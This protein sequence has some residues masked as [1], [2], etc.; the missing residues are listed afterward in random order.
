MTQNGVVRSVEAIAAS[1]MGMKNTNSNKLGQLVIQDTVLKER[2]D[3]LVREIDKLIEDYQDSEALLAFIGEMSAGK[4]TIINVLIRYPLLPSASVP[5]S[6]AP[7][8]IR[9]GSVP[10]LEV[11]TIDESGSE[12]QRF[13]FDDPAEIDKNTRRRLLEYA[14]W[15]RENSIIDTESLEYYY[16]LTKTS[17][18]IL[19]DVNDPIRLI[20]L[21]LI[22]LSA[23]TGRGRPELEAVEQYHNAILQQ[24]ELLLSIFG[25]EEDLPYAVRIRLPSDILRNGLVLV[26]L[27]GLGSGNRLHEQITRGYM[28]RADSYILPF[29]PEIRTENCSEALTEIVKYER[30]LSA[31]KDARFIV[32]LN[33]CDT[34]HDAARI[35]TIVQQIHAV[36]TQISIPM[37]YTISAYYGEY[38][39]IEAG[40]PA[41]STRWSREFIP[42][43][44]SMQ[45]LMGNDGAA[46]TDEQLAAILEKKYSS[47]FEYHDPV[48]DADVSI[49]T[50]DF[51]ENVIG[52]FA[53]RIRFLNALEQVNRLMYSHTVF[54]KDLQVRMELVHMLSACGESMMKNLLAII[55]DALEGCTG[56]LVT[57]LQELNSSIRKKHSE[58]AKGIQAA[59]NEYE[60][61]FSA[62]D[63]AMKQHLNQETQKIK[64]NALG[65]AIIDPTAASKA[66]C[67]HNLPIYNGLILYF[68]SFDFDQYLRLADAQLEAVI[69]DEQNLYAQG[70]KDVEDVFSAFIA[71]VTSSLDTVYTS[72][73]ESN[74][75]SLTPGLMATYDR[76]Y[77]QVHE[78]VIDYM[79]VII[80]ETLSYMRADNQF[81]QEMAKTRTQMAAAVARVKDF[82]HNYC[83]SYMRGAVRESKFRKKDYIDIKTIKNQVSQHFRTDSDNQNDLAQLDGIMTRD[84]DCHILR[85]EAVM[86]KVMDDLSTYQAKRIKAYFPK[87]REEINGHYRNT[88]LDFRALFS[89]FESLA[90]QILNDEFDGPESFWNQKNMK[91]AIRFGRESDFARQLAEEAEHKRDEAR[92]AFEQDVVLAKQHK[93]SCTKTEAEGSNLPGHGA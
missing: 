20:Q 23:S 64:T 45:S 63:A 92:Q 83:V 24:K 4:S 25:V 36:L 31:G 16:D 77:Q 22:V 37:I 43:W 17:E 7:V 14:L 1:I 73:K 40:F 74:R 13:L 89:N 71:N 12:I 67:S 70:M 69:K 51:M 8:E 30:M 42:T 54:A 53:P 48:T 93:E 47:A 38:R 9:Y 19:R 49:S 32:L 56:A 85:I 84:K 46:I 28:E 34:I 60:R 87:L 62:A 6:D 27:P 80:N 15:L 58:M 26:D 57:K 29:D 66:V 5:T 82:Y 39:M 52:E 33:K 79:T 78:A 86:M 61:G 44:K 35:K 21:M 65:H 72:F 91:D 88:R 76:C 3:E 18:E 75:S 59:R 10:A 68:G 41:S 2:R 55:Q 81:E 90:G 50:K 11:V